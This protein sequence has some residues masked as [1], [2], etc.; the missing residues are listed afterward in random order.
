MDR[1]YISLVFESFHFRILRVSVNNNLTLHAPH[2]ESSIIDVASKFEKLLSLEPPSV[3]NF[4]PTQISRIMTN[5]VSFSERF[6]NS[7]LLTIPVVERTRRRVGAEYFSSCSLF[8]GYL[9]NIFSA[10]NKLPLFG[11]LARLGNVIEYNGNSSS[12]LP[13]L[14]AIGIDTEGMFV[15][16][17]EFQARTEDL[18]FNDYWWICNEI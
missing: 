18:F 3:L 2:F 5:T 12:G 6:K 15:R 13:I 16:C 1:S 7:L 11:P 9:L 17:G 14:Q 4:L 10:S 8:N